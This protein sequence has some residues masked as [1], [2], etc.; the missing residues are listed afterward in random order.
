V[1]LIIIY[2]PV[3]GLVTDHVADW[4]CCGFE[5]QFCSLRF[6]SED[7]TARGCVCWGGGGLLMGLFQYKSDKW[8]YW[9]I[10]KIQRQPLPFNLS[11]EQT[12]VN[13]FVSKTIL[14]LVKCQL[15]LEKQ[16]FKLQSFKYESL[17]LTLKISLVLVRLVHLCVLY[18]SHN[19]K[20]LF[21]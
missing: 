13:A 3:A 12:T 7:K 19:E 16:S 4:N 20:R 6:K 2:F 17:V 10:S 8:Q 11:I 5:P 1:E 15:A 14:W 9:L 18:E 21:P